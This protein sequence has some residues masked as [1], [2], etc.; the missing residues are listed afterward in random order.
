MYSLQK[1]S[2][3][4]KN[5]WIILTRVYAPSNQM[6]LD[7]VDHFFNLEECIKGFNL[8][9]SKGLINPLDVYFREVWA[10]SWIISLL[11]KTI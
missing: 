10:I 3:K 2:E 11:P 6:Y 1:M 5:R 9:C 7:D 8:W 4:T